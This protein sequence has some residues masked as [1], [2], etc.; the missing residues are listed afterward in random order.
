ME[1]TV[2]IELAIAVTAGSFTILGAAIA[3]LLAFL[4]SSHNR[5]AAVRDR[6]YEQSVQA[7]ADFIGTSHLYLSRKMDL[8]SALERAKSKYPD[9]PYLGDKLQNA[10]L[11]ELIHPL[12]ERYYSVA[13]QAELLAPTLR[14]AH[15]IREMSTHLHLAGDYLGLAMNGQLPENWREEAQEHLEKHDEASTLL[16][17]HLRTV[18]A[19]TS[20]RY[21]PG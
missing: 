6:A 18:G 5:K 16:I 3:A 12:I 1:Q 8:T 21:S 7:C 9:T 20:Y 4:T 19:Q 10:T 14:A 17:E 13:T 11:L 15:L 2:T